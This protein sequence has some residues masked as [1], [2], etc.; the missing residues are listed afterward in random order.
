MKDT[1]FSSREELLKVS[2]K[3][4]VSEPNSGFKDNHLCIDEHNPEG[5]HC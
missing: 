2:L 4:I 1:I 5:N 3:V